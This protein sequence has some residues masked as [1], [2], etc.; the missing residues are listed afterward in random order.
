[1]SNKSTTAKLREKEVINIC[2]GKRLGC[3]CDFEFDLCS[4]CITALIIPSNTGFFG[5]GKSNDIY[6]PW[7][8]IECIGEDTILVKMATEDIEAFCNCKKSKKNIWN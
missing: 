4:A 6:I 5:M 7:D 2:D 8:K 1:M 3:A